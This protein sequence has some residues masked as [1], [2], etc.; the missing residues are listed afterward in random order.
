MA[1]PDTKAL[2]WAR[3]AREGFVALLVRAL[4]DLAQACSERLEVL[5]DEP[6]PPPEV[7]LRRDTW[8]GFRQRRLHWI[9]QC[10]Q[11]LQSALRA[12]PA[13][14]GGA[15]P[16]ASPRL[17]LLAEGAVDDQILAAR[18]AMRVLDACSS[19]LNELRLRIQHLEQR[20][21]L[22]SGDV[23]LPDGVARVLVDQWLALP[24]TREGWSL[25]Q[26]ALAPL[27]AQRMLAAY[28]AANAFLVS[29]GVMREIDL[30]ALVR[31]APAGP[32]ADRR[33]TAEQHWPITGMGGDGAV[34]SSTHSGTGRG[35]AVSSGRFG[36]NSFASSPGG[37]NSLHSSGGSGGSGVGNSG[38]GSGGS[39]GSGSGGS[40]SGGS[41]GSGGGS[42]HA[43]QAAAGGA[44]R[45]PHD[46]MAVRDET[47]LMTGSTPLARARMRAQ[48]V[49]GQ[50]KRLLGTRVGED[51]EATRAGAATSPGLR[52]ALAQTLPGVDD[53]LPGPHGADAPIERAVAALRQRSTELKAAAATPTE[54]ATIEVVALMFQS[55]LTEE[56]LPA[57]VRLWFARLQMP[58]LRVALAE[59]AF[60]GALDHPARRLIDRMGACV[61]GFDSDISPA[62]LEDEIRRVVQVIEQYPET[63]RRVFQLV[64][65]EFEAF[66]ASW[67]SG[68][69][70][71]GRVVSVAQQIEQKEAMSV[72]YTIELRKL[73]D[74]VPV[75]E[76]IRSFLFKV[77]VDVL[78]LASVKYGPQH[79]ETVALKRL[80]SELLWAASGK[81]DRG[82]R[83]RLIQQLPGLLQ[84]LRQGMALL[85]YPPSVQDAHI[86]SVS[87][88][89]TDAFLSRTEAIAQ[90]SL[91]QLARRLAQLEDYLPEG[92]VGDLDLDNDSI[93]LITGVD[94]SNIEVIRQGGSQPN[95]AMRAWTGEL[96]IGDWFGLD[97]NGR[98]QQVQLAWRSQHGQLYLFVTGGGRCYLVQAH[99]V[100]AY[101]QA[102]LLVPTEDEALT[103]RATRAALAKLDANPE[104]L[105]S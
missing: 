30:H 36:Q 69:G 18:L 92:G 84:K 56:R 83:A 65:D 58:V 1:P 23:L 52:Q 71:P 79:A 95:E 2:T 88:T 101:L 16:G 19:E 96:Q 51:F 105:L 26:D 42:G 46:R 70:T 85:G 91:D 87:D 29:R 20:E 72:Q 67:L 104:R 82:E 102:G 21:E 68:Q 86:Q 62:Q 54:K 7:Q 10:E 40:G 22:P 11:A 55:I 103:V 14:G 39:G 8:A 3:Q 76:D 93:E 53:G 24:L 63:G 27:L 4:P 35:G 99:R 45:A 5:I 94:A 60:F 73:L 80:A 6:R 89:L 64:Y 97:H 9:R 33:R 77:W 15:R 48:G 13:S 17:E 57:S 90:D 47:R 44:A 31:R 28:E 66:L 41:G 50:L 61:L 32:A 34:G 49:V 25:V 59:P 75:N 81:A 100:A 12:R 37:W 78:A 74:E 43:A 98:L 38:S